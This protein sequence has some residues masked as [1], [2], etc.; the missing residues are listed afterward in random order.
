MTSLRHAIRSCVAIAWCVAA[1]AASAGSARAGIAYGNLGASGTNALGSTNTD[2]GPADS[3][4]LGLAQGFTSGSL[5]YGKTV[6]SVSLGL[7]F[8]NSNTA[9]RTVSIYSDNAGVPG[10]A[11]YTSGT[12]LVG[13]T[14]LY[15]FNFS[16]ANLTDNTPYWIV[17]EGPMS[18]YFNT[19]ASAPTGLNGYGYSYL[20]TK[21][22]NTSSQWVNADFPVYSIS[23]SAV[24]EPAGVALGSIGVAAAACILRRRRS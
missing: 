2:F 8:D 16:G 19:P 21:S 4:E 3:N 18:W 9:P 20:G 22:L 15:T 6:E 5:W 11:L 17:P 7:F 10:S 1:V 13:N 24:P 14:G 12:T 23:I